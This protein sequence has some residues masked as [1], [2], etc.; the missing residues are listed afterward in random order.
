MP[1]RTI[2]SEPCDGSRSTTLSPAA[3]ES[4]PAGHHLQGVVVAHG[5][6]DEHRGAALHRGGLAAECEHALVG[7][8][9]T[10][11]PWYRTASYPARAR[12]AVN[13]ESSAAHV[14][15]AV[16]ARAESA[17]AR[18]TPA[19]SRRARVVSAFCPPMPVAPAGARRV[20]SRASVSRAVARGGRV[21]AAGRAGT[22]ARTD[23]GTAAAST[24]AVS[25]PTT[26]PRTCG[27]RA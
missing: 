10:V 12:S 14:I 25:V 2:T 16:S 15:S 21:G 24:T 6:A 27:P 1:P 7:P 23:P 3:S 26:A 5:V 11:S 22:C 8:E 20:E 17:P 9:R 18:A 19:V 4:T 13:V